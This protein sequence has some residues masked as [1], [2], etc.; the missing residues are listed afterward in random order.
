M[1]A[2]LFESE[3]G[4]PIPDG[5]IDCLHGGDN[6]PWD[7]FGDFQTWFESTT[8]LQLPTVD[9]EFLAGVH[10]CLYEGQNCPS[11]DEAVQFVKDELNVDLDDELMAM[12]YNC[13]E[14]FVKQ[15]GFGHLLDYF[16]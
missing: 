10:E 8:K 1:V 2:G 7:S 14:D 9:E 12:I 11:L 4:T 5:A 3:F 6:C 15:L 13:A 16:N